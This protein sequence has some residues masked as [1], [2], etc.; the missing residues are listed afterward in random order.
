M[1]PTPI[2]REAVEA[3]IAELRRGLWVW[4][5]DADK[6]ADMLIALLARAEKGEEMA[7][8]YKNAFRKI[9]ADFAAVCVER[10]EARKQTKV[11]LKM[12]RERPTAPHPIGQINNLERF[13]REDADAEVRELT[14]ERDR[15]A[16]ELAAIGSDLGIDEASTGPRDA[17]RNAVRMIAEAERERDRLAEELA[18]ARKWAKVAIFSD[19]E[20]VKAVDQRADEIAAENATLTADLAAARETIEGIRGALQ[21]M[22]ELYQHANYG[23]FENGVTDPT[24]SIDEGNVIASRIYHK[25]RAAL[26]KANKTEGRDD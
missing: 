16:G 1:T 20:Y 25:A 22:I 6:V 18:E 8:F 12:F 7:Q 14:T 11:A 4:A 13:L 5:D 15:L 26:A 21:C 10:D 23:A 9:E 24:G 17:V 19:S 3:S 2:T